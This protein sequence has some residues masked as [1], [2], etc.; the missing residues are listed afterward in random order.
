MDGIKRKIE[1]A[2]R[3]KEKIQDREIPENIK[4]LMEKL[5]HYIIRADQERTN[6]GMSEI[7]AK[8]GIEGK[9]C[10]GSE[11]ELKYS[12]ELL[13][14]NLLYGV[15]LPDKPHF[16]DKC[17]FLTS[18]GCC[19]FARDVFCINFICDK[20]KKLLSP[21]KLKTLRTL[22]GLQIETQFILE[23]FFKKI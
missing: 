10:C 6:I 5:N 12:A 13:L 22:E 8:C 21:D 3:K 2:L 17:Y 20:I 19:L 14:I 18:T 1:I 11:I 4:K 23:E 16:S 9:S 15:K 7:C